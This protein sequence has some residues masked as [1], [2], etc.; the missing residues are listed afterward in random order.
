MRDADA[1][2]DRGEGQRLD[3]VV[4]D[5]LDRGVHQLL[6]PCRLVLRSCHA[7]TFSG[8]ARQE[9]ELSPLWTRPGFPE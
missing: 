3:A 9:S 5:Q 6:P 7:I 2:S 4:C 1:V 8:R